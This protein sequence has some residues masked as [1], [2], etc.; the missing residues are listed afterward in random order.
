MQMRA[1]FKKIVAGST[2][3]LILAIGLTATATPASAWG[4]RYGGYWG[5]PGWGWGPAVGLGVLGGVAAGA[6]IASQGPY[7]GPGPYN[8][9]RMRP[10]YDAYGHYIGRQPVNV[11]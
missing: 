10:I 6:I 1:S 2:A 3:A 11:C 9:T 5:H 8:C 4:Y 7:Y